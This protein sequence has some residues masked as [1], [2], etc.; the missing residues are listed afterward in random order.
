MA[1]E[2]MTYDSL[3]HDIQQILPRSTFETDNYGQLVIYTGMRFGDDNRTL[4]QFDTVDCPVCK[5]VAVKDAKQENTVYC[6]N[7][8]CN[9]MGVLPD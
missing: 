2:Q 3:Y 5:D 1:E 9:F 8:D 7:P 4:E 6:K